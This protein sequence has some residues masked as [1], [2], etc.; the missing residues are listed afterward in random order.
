MKELFSTSHERVHSTKQLEEKLYDNLLSTIVHIYLL[1]VREHF[2]GCNMF[3]FLGKKKIYI[4]RLPDAICLD[5]NIQFNIRY[6]IFVW[7][8]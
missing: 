4:N 6:L 7:I 1:S 5:G 3:W 8:S 2:Y